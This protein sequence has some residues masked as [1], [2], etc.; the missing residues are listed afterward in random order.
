MVDIATALRLSK[1]AVNGFKREGM[2]TDSIEAAQAWYNARRA[3]RGADA[4][5]PTGEIHSDES[6]EQIV[7]QHRSLKDRA[8]RKYLEDLDMN[9]SEQA[10]SYATYDKLLK[11]MVALER[12][13]VAR[14]IASRKYIETS[15]AVAVFGK[16]LLALRNDMAQLATRIAPKANPDKP[17]TAMK[18][19]DDEVDRMM[20][21]HS[22]AADDAIADITTP[23]I[24]TSSESP[25]DDTQ[26]DEVEQPE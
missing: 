17:G 10:K 21:R 6:F 16:I 3:S 12:E 19:V 14:D 24:P 11:T 7:A 25:T 20:R 9:S 18:A 26:P 22:Q 8:Y 15:Q 2:P 4:V 5:V 1:Q 23:T 13:A